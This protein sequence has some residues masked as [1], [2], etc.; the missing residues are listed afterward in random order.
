[1]EVQSIMMYKSERFGQIMTNCYF[2]IFYYVTKV[3]SI[4][5]KGA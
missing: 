2:I 1:M 4:D 3:S 5:D